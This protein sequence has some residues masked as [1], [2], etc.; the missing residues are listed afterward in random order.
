M[1]KDDQTNKELAKQHAKNA[2]KRLF[3]NRTKE[4]DEALRNIKIIGSPEN[5]V[6]SDS[7]ESSKKSD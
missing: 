3:G 5:L 2:A 4:E 1:S 6:E 7:E